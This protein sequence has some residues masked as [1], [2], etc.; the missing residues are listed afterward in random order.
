ME[1]GDEEDIN[2]MHEYIIKFNQLLILRDS[3]IE[4]TLIS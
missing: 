3:F 4:A 1:E 2:R